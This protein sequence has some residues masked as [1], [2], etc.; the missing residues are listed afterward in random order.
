MRKNK[1]RQFISDLFQMHGKE[2]QPN[3]TIIIITFILVVF[4]LLM[5]MSASSVFSFKKFGNSYYMFWHQLL[6]GVLPGVIFYYF[7]SKIDFRIWKKF[8]FLM[9][10]AS[11]GLLLIVFIPGIG[12]NYGKA[13]SWINIFGFSLQPSE[14]VKLTFL[15][16]LASWFDSKG[17]NVKDFHTGF[18]PFILILALIMILMF[19]Q[20]D[21]G[22]MFIIFLI[23][24]VCFYVGESDIKHFLIILGGAFALAILAI[25]IAPYR[26][27]RFLVF[28]NPNTDTGG[29][30][31]H[32]NQALIAVG[33][34]GIFGMG[35]GMSRQKYGYLP[36]VAGDSIFGIV[37]EELGFLFC[38]IYIFL[39]FLLVSQGIKIAKN[40]QDTY[41]KVLATGIVMWIGL[42]S[43]INIASII[44]L[45]PMTGVP[46][47]FI[48]YGGT[49]MFI[50]L[51]AI[52]ILVNMSKHTTH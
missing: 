27:A 47:P 9:L 22:T 23:S 13:H 48:S 50:N 6:F 10:L 2:H 34:G 33:S 3:Y 41:A 17:R 31:Y 38:V 26:L 52:G 5:L 16:Y 37:A 40:S 45:V 44:G 11:I 39:I 7:C 42:Q 4:G 12:A 28:I 19:L 1:A 24:M 21:L 35:L 51:A 30:G 18:L 43:F 36:E 20:P 46:L 25:K 29:I 49:A 15:L 14:I 32:L 8:S